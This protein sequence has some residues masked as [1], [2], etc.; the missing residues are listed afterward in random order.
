MQSNVYDIV[1]GTAA[2]FDGYHNVLEP[3][4]RGVC[5]L[6]KIP[7][8]GWT[9]IH[10]WGSISTFFAVVLVWALSMRVRSASRD[11]VAVFL[12]KKAIK[13]VIWGLFEIVKWAWEHSKLGEWLVERILEPCSE[14]LPD[15]MG[16]C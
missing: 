13:P 7:T 9:D 15:C 16:C 12:W 5:E 11:M 3:E 1:R 14:R 6:V 4:Y 10:F 8:L 2:N